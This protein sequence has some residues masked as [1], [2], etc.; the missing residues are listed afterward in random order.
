VL[1]AERR[2]DGC[3][4]YARARRDLASG[5]GLGSGREA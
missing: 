1:A 3:G 5:A 2:I 4:R